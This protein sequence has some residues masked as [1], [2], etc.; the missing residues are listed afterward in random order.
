LNFETFDSLTVPSD[1]SA[2]A[3]IAAALRQSNVPEGVQH[4]LRCHAR[5]GLG[6]LPQGTPPGVYYL[7]VDAYDHA[8]NGSQYI[9]SGYPSGSF[10]KLD[11]NPIVTVTNADGG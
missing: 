8:N 4:H 1:S 10:L 7:A 9:S 11:T 6:G 5:R 2:A 3:E